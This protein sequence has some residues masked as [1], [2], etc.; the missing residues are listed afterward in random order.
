[1]SPD[2][3]YSFSVLGN[4]PAESDPGSFV[5]C[6]RG[7]SWGWVT[8]QRVMPSLYL[9][10]GNFWGGLRSELD[11][12]SHQPGPGDTGPPILPFPISGEAKGE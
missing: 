2:Y 10:L 12:S 11:L 9:E 8:G 3:V 4:T 6:P 7:A 5:P 1:M